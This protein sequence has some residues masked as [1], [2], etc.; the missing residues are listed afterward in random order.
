[1]LENQDGEGRIWQRNGT[2]KSFQVANL[3]KTKSHMSEYTI[4]RNE[5]KEKGKYVTTGHSKKENLGTNIQ[6]SY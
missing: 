2:T 3:T 4:L 6:N 5:S 1:M